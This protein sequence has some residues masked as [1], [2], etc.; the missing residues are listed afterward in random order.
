MG[1]DTVLTAIYRGKLYWFWGDTNRPGHPLGNFFTSGATSELPGAGGLDPSIGV[2]LRYFTDPQ[3]GFAK[4]M[5]LRHPKAN[6]SNGPIWVDGILTVADDSGQ[7]RLLGRYTRVKG[8]DPVEQGLMVYNDR[9]EQFEPIKTFALSTKLFPSGHPLRVHADGQEYFYFPRPYPTVRVKNAWNSVTDLSA[10]E[11]FTCLK[12]GSVYHEKNPPLDRDADGK[13]LWK[14]RKNAQLL[15]AKELESLIAS[16]AVKAEEIPFRLRNVN[17]G[18]P[19]RL[20]RSSVYWNDYRRKWLMIGVQEAGDSFLGE[21]W[22]AEANAPEGPWVNAKKIATHA[23]KNDNQDF[24]NP[25]QHPYF[26]QDGG[27]LI[28]FEGTFVNTFSGNPFPTPNYDY[29]QIMYRL[30]L[31]DP[32]LKLPEPP[33]GLSNSGPSRLGP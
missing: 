6:A 24:Y 15:G 18:K 23:K 26:A 13:L 33:A 7:P 12:D 11:G 5:V 9:A 10:Y 14:W 28:Y 22:F 8:L 1:Q 4:A 29:N 16:R 20:H 17:D 21:V 27:K 30:D 2:N 32:R 25:A 3:T 19:I 31:S